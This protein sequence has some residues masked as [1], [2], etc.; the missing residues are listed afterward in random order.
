MKTHEQ[1]QREKQ[2]VT[3]CSV[4]LFFTTCGVIGIYGVFSVV[5]HLIAGAF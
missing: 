1:I 5:A 2:E 3:D 4:V